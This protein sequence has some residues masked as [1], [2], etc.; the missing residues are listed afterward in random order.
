MKM[1]VGVVNS[2]AARTQSFVVEY[3]GKEMTYG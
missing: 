1:V 3:M 2:T